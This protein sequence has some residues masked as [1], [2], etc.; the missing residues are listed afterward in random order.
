[1][2]VYTAIYG[3][4]DYLHEHADV[5]GVEWRCYTDDPSLTS[6]DWNVI[7]EPGRFDDPRLSAKW[8]KCHPP[9]DSDIS[10]WVDAACLITDP[11]FVDQFHGLLNVD[12]PIALW[13]HP[14]RA[15]IRDELAVLKTMPAFQGMDFD[16]QVERYAE[17]RQDI[18]ALGL[19]VSTVIGRLHTPEVL[20]MSAAWFAHCALA[21]MRDQL[22]LPVML[23]DY[24]IRP[25]IIPE[26]LHGASGFEWRWFDHTRAS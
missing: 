12:A 24:G 1:M 23:A 26:S 2:I 13:R 3:G 8:R 14:Q 11:Y 18:D 10:V 6:A 17:R 21:T 22:S 16:A 25:A 20:Q 19:Y 15:R 5:A 9:L 4:F 7:Y